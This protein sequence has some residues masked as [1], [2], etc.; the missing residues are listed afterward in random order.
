MC[1]HVRRLWG[2]YLPT[3]PSNPSLRAYSSPP[4]W[5]E[6]V[7]RDVP[8]SWW[9]TPYKTNF[10]QKSTL[11]QPLLPMRASPTPL[12]RPVRCHCRVLASFF[13]IKAGSLGYVASALQNL[14][15]YLCW[16]EVRNERRLLRL[17]DT[18]RAVLEVRP[19]ATVFKVLIVEHAAIGSSE[20]LFCFMRQGFSV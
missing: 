14:L 9:Q 16:A 19:E 6:W 2:A 17:A 12:L 5:A 11:G 4:E 1:P 7:G 10:T 18:R 3:L 15:W 20:F 13:S 8:S